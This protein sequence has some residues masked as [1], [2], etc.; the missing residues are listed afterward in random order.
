MTIRAHAKLAGSVLLAI[1]AGAALGASLQCSIP[2]GSWLRTRDWP[3]TAETWANWAQTA[4][5][6]VAG[7]WTYWLFVRQRSHRTRANMAQTTEVISSTPDRRIIRV[8]LDLKNEGNVKIDVTT[9]SA[10][11]YAVRPESNAVS[12]ASQAE[13]A[14]VQQGT[15]LTLQRG[16]ELPWQE[17]LRNDFDLRSN[18]FCLEPGE[19][20]FVYCDFVLPVT[21]EA[22]LV[23]T[24]LC[25]GKEAPDLHWQEEAFYDLTLS[26]SEPRRPAA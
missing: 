17:L 7:W 23:R 22:I 3:L 19:R 26:A 10:I 12:A 24:E 16:P 1:A 5:L 2:L 9:G 8:R 6:A 14:L 21:I 20:D 25:C 4:A 18:R 13:V 15:K 11:I